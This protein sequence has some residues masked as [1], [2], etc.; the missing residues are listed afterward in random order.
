[1]R[2]KNTHHLPLL[3]Y[4][5]P[6]KDMYLI[7]FQ[8]SNKQVK[9]FL[10]PS[11]IGGFPWRNLQTGKTEFLYFQNEFGEESDLVIPTGGELMLDPENPIDKYNIDVF[12][13]WQKEFTGI[14]SQFLVTD[15]TAQ[16][17]QKRDLRK[18]KVKA[19]GL[20]SGL[21]M[22]DYDTLLALAQ[23]LGLRKLGIGRQEATD[24]LEEIADTDPMLVIGALEDSEKELRFLIEKAIA[25]R[26]LSRDA[27]G[28]VRYGPVEGGQPIGNNE[29]QALIYLKTNTELL[30]QIMSEVESKVLV[31]A[32]E[33]AAARTQK[34][35]VSGEKVLTAEELLVE[36]Q[37]WVEAGVL[38]AVKDEKDEVKEVKFSTL[39]LGKT[40]KKATDFLLKNPHY[41]TII[42]QKVPRQATVNN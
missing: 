32:P 6:N 27:Q 39:S 25:R 8:P 29:E 36:V 3:T 22:E 33:P 10:Q 40:L 31:A 1:M 9:K 12:R 21:A 4:F 18:A 42:R 26:V 37:A 7:S 19:L 34:K 30:G 16:K 14:S 38:T 23:R 28:V 20:V 17:E 15:M 11:S 41:I 13:L 35:E 5:N 2:E 24:Y